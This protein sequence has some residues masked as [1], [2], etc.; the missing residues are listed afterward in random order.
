M[1]TVS[2]STGVNPSNQ[3]IFSLTY[4]DSK[5]TVVDS[6]LLDSYVS[7]DNVAAMA[8]ARISQLTLNDGYLAS[9][10]PGPITP[11]PLPVVEPT[12]DQLDQQAY[13]Q[14][15]QDLLQ[16]QQDVSLGLITQDDF[17]NQLSTVQTI[18][19]NLANKKQ[20]TP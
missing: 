2:I 4:T 19:T 10:V 17:D 15:R 11:A 1:W 18:K 12:Q 8:D 16:A 13:D 14:Q 20:V 6:F 7:A 3:Q 5:R 9:I